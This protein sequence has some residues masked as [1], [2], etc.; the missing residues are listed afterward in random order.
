MARS[1]SKVRKWAETVG[2]TINES[3]HF[4]KIIITLPNNK[5]FE[6]ENCEST[7]TKVISRGRG[8]ML[9]GKPKGMYFME[10]P[11]KGYGGYRYKT[12]QSDAIN[13]MGKCL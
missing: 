9:D 6:L 5:K 3:E 2:A 12:T 4:D 10:I 7:I 1:F 11:E 13:T 8:T